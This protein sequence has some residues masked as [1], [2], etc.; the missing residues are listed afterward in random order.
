MSPAFEIF[1]D[2][3]T[4]NL[5]IG[6]CFARTSLINGIELHKNKIKINEALYGTLRTDVQKVFNVHCDKIGFQLEIPKYTLKINEWNVFELL[7]TES[8]CIICTIAIANR[9][10]LPFLHNVIDPSRQLLYS[11]MLIK[12]T[13]TH[14]FW[15]S[16]WSKHSANNVPVDIIIPIYKGYVETVNCINSVIQ[17]QTQIDLNIL[18]INDA[19]PDKKIAE[20]LHNIKNT[21]S[22]ITLLIN[23]NNL[24]FVRTVNRGFEHSKNDVVILNSDTEVFN[25]WIDR[26]QKCAYNKPNIGT[27]TPLSNNAEIF[28]ISSVD[29][30][31]KIGSSEGKYLDSLL[32][33]VGYTDPVD[34]PVGVG[35]CMY[36][37]RACLDSVGLFNADEWGMGYGEEVDFCLRAMQKD[38]RNVAAP[39]IFVIHYGGVSF[40][41]SKDQYI[42]EASK[43]IADKY[44]FYDRMIHEWVQVNPLRIVHNQMYLLLLSQTFGQAEFDVHISHA[45]GGGTEKYIQM[46]IDLAKQRNVNVIRLYIKPNRIFSL[47]FII[48]DLDEFTKRLLGEKLLLD[49]VEPDEICELKNSIFNSFKINSVYFHSLLFSSKRL[50]Q[51]LMNIVK[52]YKMV[53]HDY[54]LFCPRIHLYQNNGQ[55]CKEPNASS[56]TQ[57]LLRY[58]IHNGAKLLWSDLNQSYT[59]WLEFNQYFFKEAAQ[60]ICG[61]EDVKQRLV[62]H[63]FENDILVKCYDSFVSNLQLSQ[64]RI[65]D[66]PKRIA[67][68]GAI[69]DIKGFYSLRE[70]L[71]LNKE[72][73]YGFDFIVIGYTMNDAELLNIDDNLLITGQYQEPDFHELLLKTKI[74]LALFLGTIPETYSFTLSLCLEHSIYPIAMDIGAIAER[75]RANNFGELIPLNTSSE[76]ILGIINNVIAKLLLRT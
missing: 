50:I 70:L 18:L 29:K 5:I 55:Y 75:I 53:I 74:G 56:C 3:I 30:P 9:L 35:F 46:Q 71:I 21:D 37:K 59:Q 13:H 24:G 54:Y 36:M 69:S 68:L 39:N 16:A 61:S 34:V 15:V 47:E 73:S 44:P 8:K 33:Q 1:I 27:V 65:K 28:N 31:F 41:K 40:G 42:A 45:L 10:F 43:K 20:F 52:S 51:E 76:K 2:S 17:A 72:K 63:G 14:D 58:P 19:T 22:R 25:G 67:M 12:C 4:T 62:T 6:W 32:M 49:F 23:D 60:V 38:W 64:H 48:H 66:F 57:C 7:D 11:E 26:L